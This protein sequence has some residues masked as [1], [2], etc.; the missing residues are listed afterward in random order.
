MTSAEI[1]A[2]FNYLKT[3]NKEIYYNLQ[4]ILQLR[5]WLNSPNGMWVL[6]NMSSV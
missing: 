5:I 1:L 2:Y 4:Q 6:M 3:E